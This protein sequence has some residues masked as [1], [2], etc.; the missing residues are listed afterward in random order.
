MKS[1]KLNFRIAI[2]LY[3]CTLSPSCN[4]T[5]QDSNSEA[6]EEH[7]HHENEK[8]NPAKNMD[9]FYHP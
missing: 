6:E 9:G 7:H 5:H 3:C 1:H 4:H 2:F 8:N